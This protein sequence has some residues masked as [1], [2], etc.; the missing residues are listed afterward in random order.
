V[1][2]AAGLITM[3]SPLYEKTINEQYARW[4]RTGSSCNAGAPSADGAYA[5]PPPRASIPGYL[6]NIREFSLK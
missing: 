4:T 3:T 1:Q 6:L 2:G 5:E